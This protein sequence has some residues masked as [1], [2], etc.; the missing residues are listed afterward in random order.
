MKNNKLVN[1]EKGQ[2]LA[3]AV[4]VMVIALALGVG[5]SLRTLSTVSRVTN[6]DTSARV[7]AAAEGGIENFLV[8]PFN[9][10]ATLADSGDVTVI[11]YSSGQ[12]STDP[13]FTNASVTVD[14]FGS[15]QYPNGF[16]F[17]AENGQTYDVRMGSYAS[18]SIEV[19]WQSVN[20]NNGS[21]LY[22]TSYSA[23][24]VGTEIRSGCFVDYWASSACTADGNGIV[25]ASFVNFDS[26]QASCEFDVIASVESLGIDGQEQAVLPG[27]SIYW[28]LPTSVS[29]IASEDVTFYIS[30]GSFNTTKQAQYPAAECFSG[31]QEDLLINDVNIVGNLDITLPEL[32]VEMEKNG[33]ASNDRIN[34]FPIDYENNFESASTCNH[35][36]YENYDGHII[37]MDNN[38]THLRLRTINESAKMVLFPTQDSNGLPVQGYKITST[39]SIT[40]DVA[41]DQPTKSVTV[42]RRFPGLPSLYDF[43]IYTDTGALE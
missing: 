14:Y 11:D 19:C 13:I 33:V 9:E 29:S 31:T 15:T 39:G 5:I 4:A 35:V 28:E 42:Y 40:N 25:Y 6:T 21:D 3:F 37:T 16:D 18:N 26:N 34:R 43:G 12:S 32:P 24:D 30:S 7:L 36:G 38:I 41:G 2:A 22:Y 17:T 1:N 20:T 10:L 27:E 8:R 23:N